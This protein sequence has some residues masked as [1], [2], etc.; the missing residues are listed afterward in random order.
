MGQADDGQATRKGES[1]REF[2]QKGVLAGGAVLGGYLLYGPSIQGIVSPTPDAGKPSRNRRW[3]M[4]IDLRRCDG[5]GKCTEAC[6]VEHSVPVEQEWMKVYAL[7]DNGGGFYLP[8]PCMHCENAPCI[9]VCP[10]GAT[11]R[12]KDGLVLIDETRCIGCRY[13]MA[14]CPYDARYFNW[15]EPD[16]G[17]DL[18]PGTSPRG[19]ED[20][21]RG[22]VEKCT[23]C[24]HRTD[25]GRLPACVEGCPMRAIYFGDANEDFLSNGSEVI[26]LS[27]VLATQQAF[28]WKEEL[29]TEP[30]VYYLPARR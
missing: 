12:S 16:A 9:K 25:E 22:I 1:R 20:H 5:C 8:R 24:A 7:T 26:R 4:L 2:L 14:A 18:L 17:D 11:F 15:S 28:R 21:T 27:T 6:I 10:V 19:H 3:T 13:C 29:G 30:R 23:F